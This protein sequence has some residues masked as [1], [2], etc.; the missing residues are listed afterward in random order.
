VLQAAS[1][2]QGAKQH[3]YLYPHVPPSLFL[4]N[5]RISI[6]L[7]IMSQ[8]LPSNVHVSSHPCLQVKLSQLRDATTNSRDTKA[9]V[10]E[11]ALIV[12]CEAL[13]AGLSSKNGP[14]V[15]FSPV[16]SASLPSPP[17]TRINRA[18]AT[19]ATHTP[20]RLSSRKLS[21]SCRSYV[22]VWVWSKVG[23]HLPLPSLCPPPFTLDNLP[24]PTPLTSKDTTH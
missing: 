7:L 20:P 9:L 21:P 3:G 13:A 5:S 8:P 11:I 6:A 4:V 16:S 12:G 17:L 18:R 2:Y 15:R 14:R 19:W 24:R 23:L 22:Q 10:H 1:T